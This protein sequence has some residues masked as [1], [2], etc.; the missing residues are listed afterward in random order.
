MWLY[1]VDDV[2]LTLGINK[3]LH[4]RLEKDR[5]YMHMQTLV[6]N[7]K[8]SLFV[9]CPWILTD[10]PWYVQGKEQKCSLQEQEELVQP[11]T[12]VQ[13]SNGDMCDSRR[14]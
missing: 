10:P 1:A 4:N 5:R 7:M 14:T 9:R 13:V 6:T 11:I 3:R 12:F 8:F 2:F